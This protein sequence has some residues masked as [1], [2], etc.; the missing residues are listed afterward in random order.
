MQDA[1]GRWYCC[2]DSYVSV[3]TLQEVLSEK[4]YIL[5]FSRTKQRPRN[6]VDV[7]VNGSKSH[8]SNGSKTSIMQKSGCLDKSIC[9][10]QVLNHL[11]E[12]NKSTN[13]TRSLIH[14][15]G[16][17]EKPINMKIS[18]N[19]SQKNSSTNVLAS[20]G[21]KT[22]P[23]QTSDCVETSVS[24]KELSDNHSETCNSIT[25]LGSSRGNSTEVHR[26]G[27]SVDTV[28][29][30]ESSDHHSQ[31]SNSMTSKIVQGLP[32]QHRTYSD[33]GSNNKQLAP[34]NVKIAVYKNEPREENGYTAASFTSVEKEKTGSPKNERNGMTQESA[35]IQMMK[36]GL[37]SLPFS[38]GESG[39]IAMDPLERCSHEVNGFKLMTASRTSVNCPDI[40]NGDKMASSNNSNVKRKIEDNRSC[41]FLARDD[42]SRAQVEAFKELYVL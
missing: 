4:A 5:F 2:N 19:H 6:R 38:N 37:S 21:T 3:S 24:M 10:R 23:S 28:D 39:P 15:S 32:S 26:S 42:Q 9:T 40:Q 34:G 35:A 29:I 22:L 12:T 20:N 1:I 31:T 16:C 13:G 8:E 17:L 11:Q 14:K 41:I 30:V 18:A 25:S 33:S 36:R 7:V 27:A